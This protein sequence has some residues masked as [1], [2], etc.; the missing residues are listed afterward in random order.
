MKKNAILFVKIIVFLMSWTEVNSQT[1]TCSIQNQTVVSNQF[2]FD[3]YV[4]TTSGSLFIGNCDF[5]VTFNNA[6][7]T[8]PTVGQLMDNPPFTF[9][10]GAVSIVSS[11]RIILNVAAPFVSSQANFD[12]RVVQASGTAPGTRIATITVTGLSNTSGT[13]NIQWRMASPNSTGIS[14]MANTS[15]WDMTNVTVNGTFTNPADAPLPVELSSF[16]AKMYDQN[17]VKLNWE[18]QTEVNNYGFDVERTT[19]PKSPSSEGG[20]KVRGGWEKIGFVIGNG[21]S[22]S[23]KEYS[24]VDSNPTGGSKY[25]YRLKQ[26]DND[27]QYEYS[28]AVEVE[29]VPTEFSLYQNYPNPFNPVTRIRYQLPQ[30]SKV[31]IKIYNIIGAEVLELLN[32]KKEAGIYEVEFKAQ[33]L[34]SGTYIYRIIADNFTQTKKMILLK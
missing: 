19:Y 9:Y 27:G 3:I 7:F 17:K 5:V 25:L 1:F 28:D 6:N 33:N 22:N 15:P 18:T 8:S 29:V 30:E 12:S 13:A 23:S 16:A 32:V 34:P 10:G 11:N 14:N 4:Q 2:I 24:F 31:V 20:E 21:N 26:V